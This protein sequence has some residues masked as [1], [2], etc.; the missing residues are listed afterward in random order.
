MSEVGVAFLIPAVAIWI[1]VTT[2]FLIAW[3]LKNNSI[4]DIYYGPTFLGALLMSAAA[5]DVTAHP[6]LL[7]MGF[8]LA[9]WALRL[10]VRIARKNL[11]KDEDWRYRVW[12]DAWSQRGRAYLAARSYLQVFILQGFVIYLVFLPFTLVFA[13]GENYVA[14]LF[15]CGALVWAIGYAFE[16]IADHQLDHFLANPE[17][18]GKI[19]KY[20]LFRYSRRPNYFGESTLWFGMALMA[21]ALVPVYWIPVAFVS[22]LVITYVVYAITGPITES[23]WKNN[24]SYQEYARET[25]YFFPWF[26]KR[27]EE[28]A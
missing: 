16:V 12:R 24:F 22:P 23:R 25:N 28:H 4:V 26:P 11:G 10:S 7:P 3:F 14:P 8:F 20:G 21:S 19:M 9:L 6:L 2:L 15:F 18:T 27:H 13:F 1:L 17:N 5:A